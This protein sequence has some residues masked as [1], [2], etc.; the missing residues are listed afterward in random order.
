MKPISIPASTA[1]TALAGALTTV[2]VWAVSTWGHVE[3]P[4]EVQGAIITIAATLAAH[5]TTDTP[6]P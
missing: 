3:V 1:T 6:A 2:I 4:V 5:F